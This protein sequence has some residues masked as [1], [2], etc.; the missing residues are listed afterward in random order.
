MDSKPV[1]SNKEGQTRN[2]AHF[3]F[4]HICQDINIID[5]LSYHR[6]GGFAD[7]TILTNLLFKQEKLSVENSRKKGEI[8]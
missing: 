3:I 8:Q 4:N 5:C 1:H 7:T 2:N 6:I